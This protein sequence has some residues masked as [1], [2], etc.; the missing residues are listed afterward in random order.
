MELFVIEVDK[1]NSIRR[2]CEINDLIFNELIENFIFKT[3]RELAKYI[4]KRFR[5]FGVQ[6][7]YSPIVANNNSV[8]HAKPSDRKFTRGFLVLDFGCKVNGWCSDMT[9]TI[10]IGR[11]EVNE[12][13]LYDLVLNC[14][15]DCSMKVKDGVSCF[16]LEVLSRRLLGNYR[17]YYSHRLGHGI[18]RKVHE[19]PEFG[20]L[21]IDVLKEG[22]F[23]TIEPGM[24]IKDKHKNF[25][26]RIED[27][28][29]VGKN[30]NEILCKS[31]K[32]LI[33]IVK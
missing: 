1:L 4:L 21:S 19:K 15:K 12:K 11:A 25:G 29:Y 23:I 33:E 17:K 2:A 8:I 26:I 24:Y 9:R 31:S 6:K 28:L 32:K 3:E 18:G 10:F 7:A 14:Q 16:E 22:D 30:G 20:S 13:K 27:T 5:D